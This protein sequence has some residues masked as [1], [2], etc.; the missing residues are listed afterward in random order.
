MTE[1]M[2]QQTQPNNI[3]LFFGAVFGTYGVRKKFESFDKVFDKAQEGQA[4]AFSREGVEIMQGI[5]RDLG[6]L[7]VIAHFCREFYPIFKI[8]LPKSKTK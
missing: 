8:I 6:K 1:E 7:F 3:Q 2:K 4:V 5:K